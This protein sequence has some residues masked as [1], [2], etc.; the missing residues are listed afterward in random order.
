MPRKCAPNVAAVARNWYFPFF[1]TVWDRQKPPPSLSL[2]PRFSNLTSHHPPISPPNPSKS[3]SKAVASPKPSTP[4]S[5]PSSPK[6]PTKSDS[7]S[8]SKSSVDIFEPLSPIY[9]HPLHKGT[10]YIGSSLCVNPEI[11]ESYK[12]TRLVDVSKTPE[13]PSDKNT[14]VF[15]LS[16]FNSKRVRPP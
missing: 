15:D 14:F 3:D 5:K 1:F 6:S 2:V 13:K 4:K 12:I 8:D 7:K 11:L 9:T 10:I 16:S